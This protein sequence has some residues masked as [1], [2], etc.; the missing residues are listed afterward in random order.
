MGGR[1]GVR[2]F[3]ANEKMGNQK[4]ESKP[5]STNREKMKMRFIQRPESAFDRLS[6]TINP[7][8][9]VL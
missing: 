5:F 7:E 8:Q 4:Q 6:L 2:K 1:R 3:F 9:I